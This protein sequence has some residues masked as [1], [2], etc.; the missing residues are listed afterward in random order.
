[1]SA[2]P[3][4]KSCGMRRFRPGKSEGFGRPVTALPSDHSGS[5]SPA[6]GL[7]SPHGFQCEENAEFIRPSTAPAFAITRCA[8]TRCAPSGVGGSRSI[9]SQQLRVD[10]HQPEQGGVGLN[11]FNGGSRATPESSDF[12][13]FGGAANTWAWHGT[14]PAR[15]CWL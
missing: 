9:R 4:D 6:W 10:F 5:E 12:V 8:L 7:M 2:T 13:C 1:M 15:E 3:S 14:G 11:R